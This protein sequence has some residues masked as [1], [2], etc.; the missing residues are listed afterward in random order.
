M[1]EK[2]LSSTPESPRHK[3]FS[4]TVLIFLA[5]AVISLGVIFALLATIGDNV[6]N[7]LPPSSQ[8]SPGE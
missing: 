1:S 2:Q 3:P 4:R 5:L 6:P 7:E 8:G